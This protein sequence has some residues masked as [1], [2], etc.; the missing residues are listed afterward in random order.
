ME[1]RDVMFKNMTNES[2]SLMDK[3]RICVVYFNFYNC[4]KIVTCNFG[5]VGDDNL[6]KMAKKYNCISHLLDEAK[7]YREKLYRSDL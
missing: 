1:E 4:F 3:I 7:S 6:S 5:H 2:I